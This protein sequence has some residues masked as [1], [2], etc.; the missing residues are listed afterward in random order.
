MKPQWNVPGVGDPMLLNPSGRAQ[1]LL[2]LLVAGFVAA[3]EHAKDERTRL[4]MGTYM[5]NS[6][7]AA[8]LFLMLGRPSYFVP[9]HLAE[10]FLRSKYE[11]NSASLRFPIDSFQ[12]VFP[13]GYKLSDGTPL[14]AIHIFKLCSKLG[15]ELIDG[16]KPFI[17]SVQELERR[18][19]LYP[20][21]S[22]APAKVNRMLLYSEGLAKNIDKLKVYSS[23][24]TTLLPY[25]NGCQ[26]GNLS[27]SGDLS[28]TLEPDGFCCVPAQQLTIP[29]A[30][31]IVALATAALCRYTTRPETVVDYSLPRSERYN[32]KGE[33]SQRK[34]FR[35]LDPKIVT[36]HAERLDGP[37][38]YTV[39]P[40]VR[41]FVYATLRDER[42][43][44]KN[45]LKPGEPLR[46]Q[47]REP[48]IIHAE[49]FEASHA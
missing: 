27:L 11:V 5:G 45:P 42:W 10:L 47:E 46:I 19:K 20:D 48:T 38:S 49:Q 7:L 43:Y 16:V 24:D 22:M 39:K 35:F 18:M 9:G 36:H 12:L 29:A 26:I 6:A 41:G 14:T 3:E 17:L 4:M 33:K 8:Y 44:R 13:V 23:A 15:N 32:H 34:I 1:R 37:S 30:R 40:H 28:N 25:V 31:E 2:S 21:P